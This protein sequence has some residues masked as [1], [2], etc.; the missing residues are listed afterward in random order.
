[1]AYDLATA[2]P[3]PRCEKAAERAVGAA[4]EAMR[5]VHRL[6]AETQAPLD[7]LLDANAPPLPGTSS[8]AFWVGL[9]VVCLSVVS[10][11]STFL[12]LTNLTPVVPRE[13]VV[14]IVLFVNL[15]L[16]IA[17]VAVITVHGVGLWRAWEKKVA[18]ARLHARIV[19]LF[20]LIAAL[21]AVLLAVAATTTFSRALDNWFNQQPMSIVLNSL[22]VAHAYL[23]EHGQVIRTDIVN[24]AK[25]LD[26]AA[27]QVAGDLPKFRELMFAQAGL[28][29]LPVAYVVDC[30]GTIKVAVLED[31]KIPYIPPP[32]HLSAGRRRRAGAAPDAERQLPRCGDRQ[33]AQLSRL[34]PLRRRAASTLKSSSIC[35]APKPA[36]SATRVCA[37]CA[38]D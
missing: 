35:G 6:T 25:D 15:L 18:G 30:K 3:L 10:A 12:I 36:C 22:N 4:R 13:H 17:M 31:E 26:D 28:R 11:L 33:T 9:I 14:Y 34:L 7:P 19:I 5:R 16:V 38:A 29:D 2:V 37:R 8:R 20:S 27:P 23:D 24:M 32:E 1:M 21:P